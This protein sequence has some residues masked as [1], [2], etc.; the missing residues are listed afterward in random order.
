MNRAIGCNVFAF[1]EPWDVR[2]SLGGDPEM[3]SDHPAATWRRGRRVHT[4][5]NALGDVTESYI[6]FGHELGHAL[7]LAHDAYVPVP[8]DGMRLRGFV[9]LMAPNA[10]RHAYRLQA[11]ARLPALS[12][13]DRAALHAR[14]C[15]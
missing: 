3:A 9:S 13:R 10:V 8:P 4:I 7:D 15:D 14:Y 1:G 2:I 5:V 12:D 6:L 11:G